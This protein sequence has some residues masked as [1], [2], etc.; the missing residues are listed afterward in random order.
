[1]VKG[2]TTVTG[3]LG[4]LI[5]NLLIINNAYTL[6]AEDNQQTQV[7]TKV[8]NNESTD[9]KEKETPV[10]AGGEITTKKVQESPP[11]DTAEGTQI[12][13]FEIEISNRYQKINLDTESSKAREFRSLPEGF[14]ID[15]FLFHYDSKAQEFQGEAKGVNSLNNLIDDGYGNL[16]YRRYGVLDAGIGLSKFPHDY[17]VTSSGDISTQRDTYNLI[18]KFT[19][20]DRLIISTNLSVDDKKGSK[21]LTVESLTGIASDPTAIIEIKEPVNYTTTTI[22]LGMEYVDDIIDLQLDN[23]LQFF[24]NNLHDEVNWPI[25]GGTGKAKVAGDY[26]VHTL[27]FKPSVKFTDNTRLINTVSYSSVTSK[28]NLIPL[29]TGGIGDSFQKNMVEPD[30]RSLAISSILSSR[31]ISDVRLNVRYMHNKLANDTPKIKEPPSYVMLDGNSTD[32]IRYP[33]I[34]QYMAYSTNTIGADGTWLLTKRLSLDAGLENKDTSRSEEEVRKEREEKFFLSIYSTI[35]ENLSGK[36]GYTYTKRRG[37]Y[38]PT[39][40]QTIYDPNVKNDVTQHPLLRSFDLSGLNSN[41][42]SASLDYSPIDVINLGTTLSVFIDKHPDVTIGRRNARGESASAYAHY[43][44]FT[45]LLLYSEYNYYRRILDESYSWTYNST[46]SYPQDTT[47]NPD[48]T[49]PINGTIKDLTNAYII[50]FDYNIRKV[51]SVSASLSKYD[52]SGTNINLP[53]VKSMTD[54]YD[55]SLSYR[56]HM[57]SYTFPYIPLNLKDISIKSGYYIEKYKRTDYALDSIPNSG[58]DIFLG[59]REPDYKLNI[60]YLSLSLNF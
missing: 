6:A 16:N 22:D 18:F 32:L 51:L 1:M 27:S 45:D 34:P 54:I 37:D 21:P 14:Y 47:G 42:L 36:L 52:S 17:G 43:T 9:V 39:Y 4:I 49:K 59:I 40:Y 57:D 31:P 7:E 10:K 58:A 55:I 38:D 30:V 44:P 56:P 28:I 33:R 29:S 53:D 15:H 11:L 25:A 35:L 13:N 41:K 48:F 5:M 50:G 26:T 20:G 23:N 46:L 12:S 19:P 60:F 3:I 2:K 8:Q 24:S